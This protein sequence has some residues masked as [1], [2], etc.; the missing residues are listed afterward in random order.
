MSNNSNNFI[1]NLYQ[2][3]VSELFLY[4]TLKKQK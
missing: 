4:I 2:Q 1:T 3:H